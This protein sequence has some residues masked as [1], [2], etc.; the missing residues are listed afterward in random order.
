MMK[1]KGNL[2]WMAGIC[3][4]LATAAR[5]QE[6]AANP[7]TSSAKEIY[8]RQSER[9]IASAEEMPGDKYGYHPT[10]D[11][12]TFAKI[13]SHVAQSDFTLC[14]MISETTAPSG[15][16][17]T[18]TDAKE[19]LVPAL[20][21]SFDFCSK[22]MAKLQDSQM[23]DQITFF[24]GRKTPRSR[25]VIELVSDLVDH[26]SQLASYLRLNGMVPPSAQPA[27]PAK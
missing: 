18:E 23:G 1:A 5:A 11:Q 14:T 24:R 2:I 6:S 25:A 22:A 9:I 26:Y 7:V 13:I 16:E 20:K 3:L 12:W 8:D 21:A 10:A 15:F 27:K 19:K 4:V 17:V